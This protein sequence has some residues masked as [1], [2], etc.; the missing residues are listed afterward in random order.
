MRSEV[1]NDAFWQT[2]VANSGRFDD[3]EVVDVYAMHGDNDVG[4]Q[5]P[6]AM[7]LD[8]MSRYRLLIWDTLGSGYNGRSGLLAASALLAS[9]AT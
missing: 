3:G 7:T 2:M 4:S 1:R 8:I 6:R 9:L 5:N